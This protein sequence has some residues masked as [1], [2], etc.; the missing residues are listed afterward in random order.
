MSSDA[1]YNVATVAS[2]VGIG[3]VLLQDQGGGLQPLSKWARV[4]NN[5]ERGNSYSAYDLK[6]LY[7]REAIKRWRCYFEGC[8]KDRVVSDH[9]TL[10]YLLRHHNDRLKNG[11]RVTYVIHNRLRVR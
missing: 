3:T 10:R 6:T 9:E 1:T 8:S 4:L 7:V 2:V 5:V 11:K